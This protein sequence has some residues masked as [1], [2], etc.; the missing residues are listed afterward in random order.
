MWGK[1]DLW[2]KRSAETEDWKTEE[3]LLGAVPGRS[4]ERR[5]GGQREG[6]EVAE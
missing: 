5:E 4:G 2:E 3:H 1:W 6:E